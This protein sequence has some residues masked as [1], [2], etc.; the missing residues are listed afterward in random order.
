[1][2]TTCRRIQDT[3][4]IEGAQALKNDETA[5]RHVADCEDCFTVLERLNE[6]DE[7]FG[8]LP[9]L[10]VA[11]DVVERLMQRRR[12]EAPRASAPGV[13]AFPGWFRGWFRWEARPIL[14]WALPATGAAVVVLAVVMI[15]NRS[16]VPVSV[17]SQL[18]MAR[19]ESDQSGLSDLEQGRYRSD[20]FDNELPASEPEEGQ[21][22]AA[23]SEVFG[24]GQQRVSELNAVLAPEGQ[25]INGRFGDRV[26][27]EPAD[28]YK[29]GDADGRAFGFEEPQTTRNP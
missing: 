11:D 18:E 6:L 14:R 1:M 10:D 15:P 29:A 19:L 13:G 7:T 16:P 21:T 3:L 28:A 20:G 8:T 23:S 27:D 25:S 12:S 22:G 26:A 24:G 2:T 5:Q 17:E 9:P 4:A